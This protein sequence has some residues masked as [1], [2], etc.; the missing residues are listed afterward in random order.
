MLRNS[1]SC[2]ACVWCEANNLVN[3]QS[4][5]SQ[6]YLDM[7]AHNFTFADALSC[8]SKREGDQCR[9]CPCMLQVRLLLLEGEAQGCMCPAITKSS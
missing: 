6:T 3:T 5:C 8:L 1:P 4:K 2:Y 9:G 7:P